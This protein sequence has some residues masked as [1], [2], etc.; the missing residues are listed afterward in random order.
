MKFPRDLDLGVAT[1]TG[2]VRSTNEDDYVVY[3]PDD[4]AL[5]A[6][7]G[8]LVAVADGMGGAT[9][10]GEASRAAVRALTAAF[11]ESVAGEQPEARMER[12]FAAA[13]RRIYQL[14]REQP[15][16]REMGTTLTAVNL[17]GDKVVVGHVGDTRCYLVRGGEV[18]QLTQDHAVRRAEHQLT[19]CLGAGR[20][21]EIVDVMTYPVDPGDVLCLASDGLWDGVDLSEHGGALQRGPAQT[22]AT[23]LT[24]AAVE[25]G[26]ADNCTA[27]VVRIKA[28]AAPGA[29]E[30]VEVELPAREQL[31]L[32]RLRVDL[33]GLRR[34]RWPWGVLVASLAV[35]TVAMARWI[36][37]IDLLGLLDP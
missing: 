33:P 22:V 34:S 1:H 29:E 11:V 27:L 35:L 28:V 17:L 15:R 21:A 25:A 7:L 24:T 30:L 12:A 18:R 8:E 32:P 5:R 13:A 37:G 26:G 3:C 9:G 16:L 2:R 36:W 6:R 31:H 23:M 14:A 10:G 20:E 19:R 4:A